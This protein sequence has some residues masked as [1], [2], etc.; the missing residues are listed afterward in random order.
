MS[1]TE[2]LTSL[3][4][5]KVRIDS[6]G[7][8]LEY[9]RP[10]VL[11]SLTDHRPDPVT[12]TSV[13][14]FIRADFGLEIPARTIQLILQRIGKAGILRREYGVFHLQGEVPNPGIIAKKAEAERHISAIVDGLRQ[15]SPETNPLKTREE[16]VAALVQ[17]LS[18]F[19]VPYLRA[20]LRGTAIPALGE[21]Q[22]ARNVLVSQYVLDLHKSDPAR[23]DS[24][25]VLLQGHMLANSLLCP[26]LQQA[27]RS[28]K[29]VTF[30]LDTPLLVRR[31]GLEGLPKEQAAIELIGLV[32]HLGG[33]VAAF[34]HSVEELERVIRGA[35]ENLEKI[36][37]RGEIIRFARSTGRSRSDL[38]LMAEKV[39]ELLVDSKIDVQPTPQYISKFQIDEAAFAEVLDDEISY[40]NPRA[41]DYDINSVRSIYVL[42]ANS[43]PRSLE[44]AHA[45]LVTSNSSLA[46]AAYLYGQQHEASREVSSVVTD[47]SLANMAWLKAPMGAPKLPTTELLAY[48]YAALRPSENLLDKFLRE[49]DKLE[50]AGKLTARDHQLLRSSAVAQEELMRLTLGEE[51]ALTDETVSATLARVTSEIKREERDLLIAESE[52]HRRTQLERDATKEQQQILLGGIYWRHRRGA[53]VAAWAVSIVVFTL[54]LCGVIAGI[55]VSTR[56]PTAGAVLSLGSMVLGAVTIFTWVNG[57]TARRLHASIE[58]KVFLWLLKRES[59]RLGIELPI[60]P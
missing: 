43:A 35:A 2:T 48:A 9:L 56:N 17:F 3:A 60:E 32:R 21:R 30:F 42:R 38:L 36:D 52:S 49:V 16:A 55:G 40:L 15:Y 13:S 51:Q 5:L 23:F 8:Y 1:S 53:R 47:F 24:F 33:K 41:R 50:R 34:S 14:H 20:Y 37:A 59:R 45:A 58:Q 4:M 26:D 7:D 28:Y 18:E 27:P 11:Q 10:F 19:N 57:T 12:E 44:R 25:I 31:L 6:G 39:V 29:E 54:F 46:R 22:A